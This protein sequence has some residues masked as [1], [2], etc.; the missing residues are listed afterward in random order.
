MQ[1]AAGTETGQEIEESTAGN[2]LGATLCVSTHMPHCVYAPICAS[3]L[4]LNVLKDTR[5]NI[6]SEALQPWDAPYAIRRLEQGH[7]FLLATGTQL[8]CTRLSQTHV[9]H[10]VA[11]DK[12]AKDNMAP[13][14]QTQTGCVTWPG[15]CLS[16]GHIKA[17]TKTR[18]QLHLCLMSPAHHLWP[19]CMGM[20]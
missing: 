10:P 14:P 5:F 19:S 4:V 15:S 13:G 17:R 11:A 9:N 1:P 18:N 2:L 8:A 20:A 16:L 12:R 3:E 6:K 7:E